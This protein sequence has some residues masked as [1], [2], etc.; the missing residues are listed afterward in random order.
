MPPW[1]HVPTVYKSAPLSL[2]SPLFQSLYRPQFPIAQ[3]AARALQ[4]RCEAV[5]CGVTAYL[6]GC[7][8]LLDNMNP[9]P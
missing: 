7:L 5:A 8:D 6:E 1:T 3:G 9:K 4:S 2:E